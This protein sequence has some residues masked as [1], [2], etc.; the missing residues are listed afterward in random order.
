MRQFLLYAALVAAAVFFAGLLIYTFYIVLTSKSTST[1]NKEAIE[2]NTVK[3]DPA[4]PEVKRP[5][6][7]P[8]PGEKPKKPVNPKKPR[9]A[10]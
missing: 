9:R 7:T 4:R 6:I 2:Q 10:A 8:L 1:Y 5:Q 3:D